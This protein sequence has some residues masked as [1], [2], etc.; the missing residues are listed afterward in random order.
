MWRVYA[1]LRVQLG[2]FLLV[3]GPQIQVLHCSSSLSPPSP[4]SPLPFGRTVTSFPAGP[5][6]AP[7]SRPGCG[8]RGQGLGNP[9]LTTCAGEGGETA[10]R[11][12]VLAP[13]PV[14][15]HPVHVL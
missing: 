5:Q 14:S 9:L 1:S 11:G 3:C 15:A 13:D 12:A 6:A 2:E 7:E 4:V 8:D 10:A